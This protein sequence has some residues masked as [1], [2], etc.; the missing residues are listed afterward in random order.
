MSHQ[1]TCLARDHRMMRSNPFTLPHEI[2]TPASAN[3]RHRTINFGPSYRK[4]RDGG[5]AYPPVTLIILLFPVCM[6]RQKKIKAVSYVSV[7][8]P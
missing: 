8:I 1:H 2:G 4:W 6:S 3:H 5:G 7:C